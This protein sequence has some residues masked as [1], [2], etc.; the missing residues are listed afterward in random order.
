MVLYNNIFL[1]INL[2]LLL[3]YVDMLIT[4]NIANRI[5]LKND[6]D[7]LFVAMLIITNIVIYYTERLVLAS[8]PQILLTS[9]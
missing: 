4:N 3:Y 2:L 1:F 5:N 8:Y 9:Y 7:N 6:V